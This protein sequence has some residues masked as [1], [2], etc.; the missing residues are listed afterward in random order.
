ML[1]CLAMDQNLFSR[2][3]KDNCNPIAKNRKYR[4][5]R[6]TRWTLQRLSGGEQEDSKS[7]WPWFHLYGDTNEGEW[8]SCEM[9]RR[10]VLQQRPSWTY[11]SRFMA[12]WKEEEVEGSVFHYLE[13]NE[14]NDINCRGGISQT[15][16][17]WSPS[18]HMHTHTNLSSTV[19]YFVLKDSE[20]F[21][22]AFPYEDYASACS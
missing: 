2:Q 18:E 20:T 9:Q 12:K 8:T 10:Q 21:I 16:W 17:C 5:I 7:I 15:R 3:S 11:W 4:G 1:T 19:T 6:Q 13:A 22:G 14:A